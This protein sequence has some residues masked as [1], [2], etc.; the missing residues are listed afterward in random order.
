MNAVVPSV[1]RHAEN[2]SDRPRG[3]DLY[4]HIRRDSPTHDRYILV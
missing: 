1:K 2:L 3:L 4:E